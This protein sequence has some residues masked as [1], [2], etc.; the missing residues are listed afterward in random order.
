MTVGDCTSLAAPLGRAESRLLV[1]LSAEVIFQAH[2]APRVLTV[3]W[4]IDSLRR[5][6][7]LGNKQ[8]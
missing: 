5:I 2:S 3:S 1:V 8:S 7:S 6:E 4:G